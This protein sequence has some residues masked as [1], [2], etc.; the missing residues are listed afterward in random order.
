MPRI[1]TELVDGESRPMTTLEDLIEIGKR[2]HLVDDED[3]SKT[4]DFLSKLAGSGGG[5]D[6]HKQLLADFL[7]SLFSIEV[8]EKKLSAMAVDYP[9]L[10]MA[11]PYISK[12]LRGLK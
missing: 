6:V 12:I 1:S 9:M 8:V 5:E 11:I 3:V 4:F 2:I 10:G 7:T